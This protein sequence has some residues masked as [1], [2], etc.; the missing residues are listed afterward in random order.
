MNLI[1]FLFACLCIFALFASYLLL[2]TDSHTNIWLCKKIHAA[3]NLCFRANI[4][5]ICSHTGKF[6]V[7]NIRKL[8]ANFTFKQIFA[9]KYL[10]TSKYSLHIA[11]N[12]LRKPFSSLGPHLILGSFWKYLH[13]KKY[14]LP[15]LIVSH[16]KSA[17]LLRWE[18]SE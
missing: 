16:V 18:T 2:R 10:H 1:P 15:F 12:Y 14:S 6:L 7:Q 4:H 3:V 17:N 5:L 11:S 9:C 13:R 8:Y